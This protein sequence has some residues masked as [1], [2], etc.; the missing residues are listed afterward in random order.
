M[1]PE[2]EQYLTLLYGVLDLQTLDFRFVA[3]GHPGPVHV[4]HEGSSS[5]LK[6]EGFPV[7]F[8][9]DASYQEQSL[10]LAPGDRLYLYTDGIPDATDRDSQP[11]GAEQLV[12][13]HYEEQV[14]DAER[15]LAAKLYERAEVKQLKL[16]D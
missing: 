3:A 13:C 10:H 8:F 7:G 5:I 14:S 15:A 16:K 2:T 9:P 1:D 4:P 6:A 12:D 11:F